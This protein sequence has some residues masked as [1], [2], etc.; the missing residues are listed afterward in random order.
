M[1]ISGLIFFLGCCIYEKP[2]QFG[3]TSSDESDNECEHC[4]GRKEAHK[5]G[6]PGTAASPHD[7]LPQP[8]N[9]LNIYY[10]TS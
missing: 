3:E 10:S 9:I 7:N 2:R 6:L 5:K 4:H 1:L 8:G